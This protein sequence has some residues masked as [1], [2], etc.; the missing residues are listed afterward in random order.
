V[1]NSGDYTGECCDT[2]ANCPNAY[3]SGTSDNVKSGWKASTVTFGTPEMAVHACPQKSSVCK[4]AYNWAEYDTKYTNPGGYVVG[5]EASK[6]WTT[7]DSCTYI[8]GND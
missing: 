3:D 1:I 2:I 6:T 5:L 7:K 8:F 4:S